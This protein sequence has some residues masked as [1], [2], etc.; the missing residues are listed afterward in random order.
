MIRSASFGSQAW[1]A[2]TRSLARDSR[3][4]G[5]CVHPSRRFCSPSCC[6]PPWGAPESGQPRN[7]WFSGSG[8][9]ES[10]GSGGK[11][12]RRKWCGPQ[13][14]NAARTRF[15]RLSLP[16]RGATPLQ[17]LQP[18]NLRGICDPA[19]HFLLPALR[20]AD[21]PRPSDVDRDA[22]SKPRPLHREPDITIK[23]LRPS[24]EVCYGE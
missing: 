24:R 7:L 5:S 11:V 14:R 2:S 13:P 9:A 23:T 6:S 17:P 20:H 18:M 1:M 22:D 8:L 15:C 19:R 3:C 12:N 16:Q 10:G 4:S 21:R